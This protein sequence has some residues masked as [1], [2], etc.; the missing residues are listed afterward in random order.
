MDQAKRN[1]EGI[2]ED[3]KQ[4]PAPSVRDQTSDHGAEI[5]NEISVLVVGMMKEGERAAVVVGAARLELALERLLT[6]SM[7]LHPGGSDNLFDPDRPLGTFSAKISLAF[8]LG[9]LDKKV[10]S[11][12]QLVRKIRNDFAH[13]V[14]AAS[15]A[16]SSHSNRLRELTERCRENSYYEPIFKTLSTNQV[17]EKLVLFCTAL[18]LLIAA[19]EYSALLAKPLAVVHPATFDH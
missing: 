19:V 15:L 13:S 10:E 8:R 2:L 14:S 16:D 5:G 18:V 9:L 17:T 7:Q 12:L 1:S 6:R 4:L 3:G 11:A